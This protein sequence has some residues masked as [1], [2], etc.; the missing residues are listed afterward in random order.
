MRRPQASGF[1][2]REEEITG[3]APERLRPGRR[4]RPTRWSGR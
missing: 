4:V 2:L 1:R 3:G